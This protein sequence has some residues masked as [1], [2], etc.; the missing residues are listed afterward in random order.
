MGVGSVTWTCFPGSWLG[1][2]HTPQNGVA[3]TTACEAGEVA[4]AGPF[5]SLGDSGA[6]AGAPTW[7][8]DLLPTGFMDSMV[9][10]TVSVS[11]CE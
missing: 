7:E 4:V 10:V 11:S 5:L 3:I 1:S 8:L 2:P 6:E 9:I